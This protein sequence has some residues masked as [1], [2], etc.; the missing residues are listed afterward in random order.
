[1][2]GEMLWMVQW[3]SPVRPLLIHKIYGPAES[4]TRQGLNVF[5][6]LFL[7]IIQVLVAVWY[8]IRG[9]RDVEGVAMRP[10]CSSSNNPPN[11]S[12]I[13]GTRCRTSR[14]AAKGS[15]AACRTRRSNRV[16][17]QSHGWSERGRTATGE[18]KAWAVGRVR[19]CQIEGGR[20]ELA[21]PSTGV[22]SSSISDDG[23]TTIQLEEGIHC[24]YNCKRQDRRCAC[25]WARDTKSLSTREERQNANAHQSSESA[26]FFLH[27]YSLD[28]RVWSDRPC[29]SAIS[30]AST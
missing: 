24:V 6:V 21:R 5:L 22:G 8:V 16:R 29:I 2:I 30:L 25:V 20:Q 13:P 12:N 4:Q 1:M 23:A 26:C 7:L 9:S 18:G 11:K 28:G 14:S 17:E 27:S 3:D 15:W 19:A 10:P